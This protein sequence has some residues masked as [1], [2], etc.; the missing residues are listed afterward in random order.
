MEFHLWYCFTVSSFHSRTAPDCTTKQM[1]SRTRR[2][3]KFEAH[4]DDD[5]DEGG[6]GG[7]TC[8]GVSNKLLKIF[9]I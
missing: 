9:K 1:P 6:D 2:R 3:L 8:L 5:D 7:T 4:D